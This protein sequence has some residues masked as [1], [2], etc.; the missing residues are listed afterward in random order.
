MKFKQK[1][2]IGKALS[3]VGLMI[4][5]NACHKEPYDVVIDWDWYNPPDK[6]L[7]KQYVNDKD[8]KTIV[9]NLRPFNST[10]FSPDVFHSA[11]DSLELNYFSL[12]P[13]KITGKGAIYLYTFGGTAQLPYP[14]ADTL[15]GVMYEIDSIYYR[16][17]HFDLVRGAPPANLSK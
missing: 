17:K 9:L 1:Y 3:L 15:E 16:S 14:C 6:E 11:R 8:V 7:V 12:A 13:T 5:A 4:L 10:G 2:K